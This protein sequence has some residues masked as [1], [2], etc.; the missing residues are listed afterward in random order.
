M[1]PLSVRSLQPSRFQLRSSYGSST[2]TFATA[3]SRY[4]SGPTSYSLSWFK[5]RLSIFNL[6]LMPFVDT[7][8]DRP[9][10]IENKITL[11]PAFATLTVSASR[12][13]FICH[14]YKKHP[15]WGYLFSARHRFNKPRYFLFFPHTINMQRTGTPATPLLSNA[16]FTV[17]CIRTFSRI[18][19]ISVSLPSLNT[20]STGSRRHSRSSRIQRGRTT[21]VEDPRG[22]Q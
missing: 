6:L 1:P 16:Y 5:S 15:G 14:S 13:F 21:S 8:T 3:P 9:Q 11:S 17:L 12:K 19:S 7:F 20:A 4:G 18:P 22:K 10:N 2:A